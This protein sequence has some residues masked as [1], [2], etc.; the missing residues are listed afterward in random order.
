MIK[1]FI[2][3]HIAKL[4]KDDV[5]HY[6][7]ENNIYLNDNEVDIVFNYIK[8]NYETILYNPDKTLSDINK[9]ISDKSK[10][11]VKNLYLLYR[12]KYKNYL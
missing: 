3:K 2:K 9:Y 10:E 7:K 6:S 11:K 5:I 12:E 4:T 1:L 8:N